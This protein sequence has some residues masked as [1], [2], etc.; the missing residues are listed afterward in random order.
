M[1]EDYQ[2]FNKHINK[3]SENLCGKLFLVDSSDLNTHHIF[4]DDNIKADEAYI[5]DIWDV[6]TK[7]RVKFSDAQNLYICQADFIQAVTDPDFFIKQ[8]NKCLEERSKRVERVLSEGFKLAEE[9]QKEADEQKE[10]LKSCPPSEY[11]KET[12]F[13]HLTPAL[14]I[15]DKERPSDP[16]SFLAIYL[17][18]NKQTIND[19]R[20]GGN[21]KNN[22]K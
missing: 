5:I 1:K 3:R 13:P 10:F 12:V 17:L 2:F 22:S 19:I 11:L 8:V 4:F 7:Q 9:K 6:S 21:P 20:N 14:S 18:E 16:L 15:L